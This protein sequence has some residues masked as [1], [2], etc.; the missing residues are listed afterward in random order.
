MTE[1]CTLRQCGY[2]HHQCNHQSFNTLVECLHELLW[3]KIFTAWWWPPLD[4]LSWSSEDRCT[5]C[6]WIYAQRLFHCDRIYHSLP[7]ASLGFE[8]SV[9]FMQWHEV[10]KE[11]YNGGFHLLIAFSKIQ[12]KGIISWYLVERHRQAAELTKTGDQAISKGAKGYGDL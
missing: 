12:N 9:T 4:F 11:A 7:I 1:I 8:N 10:P 6:C 5:V 2:A 3:S